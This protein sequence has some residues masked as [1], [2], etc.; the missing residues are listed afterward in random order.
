[1]INKI[2][3]LLLISAN[4]L[5]GFTP[6]VGVPI[7][8][9]SLNAKGQ[10]Y[11]HNGSIDTILAAGTNNY[12]LVRDD[13]EAT[14]LNW[15]PFP[16]STTLTTKGDIQTYSTENAAKSV[17]DDG[18]H[19]VADST[20]PTGLAWTSAL[21][22]TLNPVTDWESFTPSVSVGFG[23]ITN[24]VGFKRR[25][26][27]TLYIRG[28]FVSGS[29]LA[30]V[31]TITIPDSLSIDTAKAIDQSGR[32]DLGDWFRYNLTNN[33]NETTYQGNWI[34]DGSSTTTIGAVLRSTSD[35]TAIVNNVNA[36]WSNGEAVVFNAEIPIQGWTSGLDAAVQQIELTAET[37]N[38]LKALSAPNGAVSG[39]DFDFLNGNCTNTHPSVCTF[40]AGIFT[41]VPLCTV[42]S[43]D[44]AV[45]C[46]AERVDTTTSQFKITCY[47]HAGTEFTQS[48]YKTITCEKTGA[49]VNKSQFIAATLKDSTI[50]KN[51]GG[52][53]ARVCSWSGSSSAAISNEYGDCVASSID[54]G[55]G[56]YTY[57]FETDFWLGVPNCSPAHI[58][59]SGARMSSLEAVSNI[60]VTVITSNG[61]GREDSGHSVVCHGVAP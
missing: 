50:T 19:L 44:N 51:S 45:F 35:T 55:T 49:D 29:T 26:G 36:I 47:N 7:P 38:T 30:S 34:Y 6:F 53:K 12:V 23:T 46:S 61:G 9:N 8:E 33:L 10:L 2:I 58:N 18:T 57:T 31:A 21:T 20:D 3:L 39:D 56:T 14:G 42:A 13:A 52:G 15:I 11:G 16:I 40:N 60:S 5:A 24:T 54:D 1:M 59:V 25:I 17:G 37:K 41:E 48:S 27:D 28:S 43:N 22:G 32:N 4:T